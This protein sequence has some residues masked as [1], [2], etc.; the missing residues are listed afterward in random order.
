MSR[1]GLG[2]VCPPPVAE[3]LRAAGWRGYNGW[4]MH[5]AKPGRCRW[6]D[7][8][9]AEMRGD[10]SSR[11]RKADQAPPPERCDFTG[12]MFAQQVLPVTQEVIDALRPKAKGTGMRITIKT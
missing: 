6:Y 9:A 7:A 4:W 5:K 11:K 12:D 1:R 8:V 2:I 3:R 10:T